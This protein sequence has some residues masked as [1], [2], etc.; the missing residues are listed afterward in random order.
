MLYST[1]HSLTLWFCLMEKVLTIRESSAK[2][3]FYSYK[4]FI[5]RSGD[6]LLAPELYHQKRSIKSSSVHILCEVKSLVWVVEETLCLIPS[7]AKMEGL[8]SY[9]LLVI[10]FHMVK[11]CDLH[12]VLFLSLKMA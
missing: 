2:Q 12:H 8:C 6:I 5:V 11:E 10:L 7:N 3:K 9:L 4:Q 1:Q